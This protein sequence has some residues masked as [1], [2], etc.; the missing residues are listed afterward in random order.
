MSEHVDHFLVLRRATRRFSA[1]TLATLQI[2]RTSYSIRENKL[3]RDSPGPIADLVRV[4][5]IQLGIMPSRPQLQSRLVS[6]ALLCT[7]GTVQ[8]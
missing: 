3:C 6:G 4:M 5:S 8:T 2:I 1:N 7:R